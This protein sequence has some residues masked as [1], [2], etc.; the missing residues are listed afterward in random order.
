MSRSI[1]GDRLR[2]LGVE[3][4]SDYTARGEAVPEHVTA[5]VQV[6]NRA[7]DVADIEHGGADTVTA[8][9]SLYAAVTNHAMKC[10]GSRREAS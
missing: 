10:I 7:A 9:V 6:W 1:A 8:L 2:G 3:L 4:A 5:M